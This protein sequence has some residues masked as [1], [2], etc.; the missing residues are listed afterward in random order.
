M[1]IV[2][3]IGGIH[4]LA[5]VIIVD[6]IHADLVSLGASFGGVAMTIAAHAKVV[7]YHDQHLED[8]FIFLV[9]IFGYLH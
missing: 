5:N 7:S 6:S 1:D 4:T 8:D 3:T 2:L 9:E